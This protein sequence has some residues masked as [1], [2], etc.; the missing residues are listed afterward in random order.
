MAVDK[1]KLTELRDKFQSGAMTP[2]QF[3]A[4]MGKL[5]E[6][7]NSQLLQDPEVR[8]ALQEQAENMA[9]VQS[10]RKMS[11]DWAK[12]NVAE[13]KQKDFAEHINGMLKGF[14][15]PKDDAELHLSKKLFYS[16]MELL[17]HCE[18]VAKEKEMLSQ[19][20]GADTPKSDE[21]APNTGVDS[22][23][24][25][26]QQEPPPNTGSQL[27]RADGSDFQYTDGEKAAIKK[28]YD[29]YG[30]QLD[31]SEQRLVIEAQ[32]R[33]ERQMGGLAPNEYSVLEGAQTHLSI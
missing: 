9:R 3:D 13:D 4:E 30:G 29:P 8:K 7:S 15:A 2:D 23:L 14:E 20:N 27:K 21:P 28:L 1:Q 6:E 31:D 17:K 12:T 24:Q 19:K 16:D 10:M 25:A 26:I 18:K 33:Y 5:V 11:I 32:H 22:Q